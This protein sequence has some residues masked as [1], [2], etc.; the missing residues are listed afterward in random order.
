MLKALKRSWMK[1][2]AVTSLQMAWQLPYK[3]P[4]A[5]MDRLTLIESCRLSMDLG[6]DQWDAAALFLLAV[7][8]ARLQT[9]PFGLSDEERNLMASATGGTLGLLRFCKRPDIIKPRVMELG[10]RYKAH[11]GFR[12]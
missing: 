12:R 5:D 4:L 2:Q 6:G 3:E 10:E 9:S 7:C 8:T 1:A 11:P